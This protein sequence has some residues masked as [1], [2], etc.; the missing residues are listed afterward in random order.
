MSALKVLII[1]C[2][3]AGPAVALF[4]KRKGYIP[5][6]L[7]RSTSAGY[8]GS[9]LG[10]APNGYVLIVQLQIT[11]ADQFHSLKVLSALEITSGWKD[12][13]Q[14]WEQSLN[15]SY[16]GTL[17]TKSSLSSVLE[18]YGH[19]MGGIP[20]S[21]LNRFLKD[22]IS[23]AGIPVISEFKVSA[24]VEEE[25]QVTVVAE[26]GRREEGG[27]VIGCDGLNSVVRAS[28]LKSNNKPVELVEFTGIVQVCL[29]L[30]LENELKLIRCRSTAQR[31]IT[32]STINARSSQHH[33]VHLWSF[34]I[35]HV[36]PHYI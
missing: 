10:L 5:V 21:F 14:P 18:R 17:L 4:L 1:G 23:S 31:H 28:I 15:F 35:F 26:D 20:R 27:F 32:H 29:L 13:I 7:E 3:V 30:I 11:C 36:L 22:A 16:D 33:H 24:I 19:P 8:E 6:V 12:V 25:D 34:F 2:G 9:A